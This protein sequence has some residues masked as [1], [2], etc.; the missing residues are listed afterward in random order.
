MSV[1]GEWT[2]DPVGDSGIRPFEL[3]PL[4]GSA[5]LVDCGTPVR[6]RQLVALLE[7]ELVGGRLPDV[8]DL[9]VG[10]QTV[11][12][13]LTSPVEVSAA[14]AALTSLIRSSVV[15][16]STVPGTVAGGTSDVVVPVVYDGDDLVE[17]ADLLGLGV[18]DLVDWHT[19]QVWTCDLV[20][21]LPGFGYLVGEH[22]RSV[23]RRTTP[24][25][26]IPAGSVALAG[27]WSGVYPGA[28]RGVGR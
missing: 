3:R 27:E 19:S 12:V 20:G 14:V 4:G 2:D 1:P 7:A 11:A 26:R 22:P 25:T 13:F 6:R 18:R 5:V 28:L 15:P 17:V 21:F 10:V 16:G 24:R 8:I 9:V 23:P